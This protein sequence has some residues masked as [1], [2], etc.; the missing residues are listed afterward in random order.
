MTKQPQYG[1]RGHLV[2]V[3]HNAATGFASATIEGWAMP[4]IDHLLPD[5]DGILHPALL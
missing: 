3:A 1:G 2:G 5:L 4:V